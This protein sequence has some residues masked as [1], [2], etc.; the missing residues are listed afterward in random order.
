MTGLLCLLAATLSQPAP[1]ALLADGSPRAARLADVE[2]GRIVLDDD[3]Q[4]PVALADL[5]EW[6]QPPEIPLRP[7]VVLADG[8]TL[9]ADTL[10]ADRQTVGVDAEL[11]GTLQLPRSGLAGL[12]LRAPGDRAALDGLL[13]RMRQRGTTRDLALLTNDDQL[14]GHLEHFTDTTAALATDAG[15]LQVERGRLAAVIFGNPPALATEPAL[16]VWLG[17][18]DGSRLL[19]T[20]LESDAAGLRA[21]LATGPLVRCALGDVVWLQTQGGRAVYLSDLPAAGYRHIPYLTLAWPYQRDRNVTGTPL[22]AAGREYPKG[23]GMHS[24]ARLTYL[25]TEPYQRFQAEL[26][27]DQQTAGGGSVRFRVFVDGHQRAVSPTVRGG[28]KPVPLSVDLAGVKRLDLVVD[29]AD[30]AD[31]LDHANWLNARLI[32]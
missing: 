31:Q 28:E 16:R 32:R 10:Q 5:V 7:L 25:L 9:V 12:V 22:R 21:A 11:W 1:I 27:I 15:P 8:G 17:T 29:F 20:R 13:E 14:E 3:R 30:R 24:T 18:R 2:P 23:L 4:R 19:A 26:A 6:G